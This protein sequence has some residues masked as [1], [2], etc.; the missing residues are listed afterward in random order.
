MRY[1]NSIVFK[2][3][4]NKISKNKISIYLLILIIIIINK[5]DSRY[6]VCLF[7][8]LGFLERS[9]VNEFVIKITEVLLSRV[10]LKNAI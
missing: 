3:Y 5:V 1:L 4:T 10:S 2:F 7:Q 9:S 6:R 8:L